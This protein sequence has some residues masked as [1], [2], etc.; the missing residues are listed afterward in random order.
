LLHPDVKNS[1]YALDQWISQI[2]HALFDRQRASIFCA[3]GYV[4]QRTMQTTGIL[5]T[6]LQVA[7]GADSLKW[8][9]FS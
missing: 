1:E 3:W 8:P 9:I 4:V 7:T 5:F 6:A 2:E